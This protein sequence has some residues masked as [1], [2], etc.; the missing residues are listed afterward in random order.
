M[1]DL[2]DAL[3]HVDVL[4]ERLA[5]SLP[6]RRKP[7]MPETA[8]HVASGKVRE[9]YE[10]DDERLLLVASD[11]ISTFDVILGTEIP[12]KDGAHW[13]FRVLVRADE[14]HRPE[15]LPRPPARRA[16]DRGAAAEHAADRM[17]RARLPR[18]LGLK[19]YQATGATS[20]HSLPAGMSESDQLPQPIFTPATKAQTGH[21]E[22]ID[23]D[24]AAELVGADVLEQVEQ[25]AIALYD[26]AAANAAERGIIIADT[27]FELG[28]DEEG[29][30]VLGDE[31]F[32]PDSSRFW[33]AD[34]YRPGGAQRPSTSSSC[35]TTA[36]GSAGTRP[37]QALS[38]RGR[39]QRD[40][41]PLCRGVRTADGYR[42]RRLPRRS[43]GG[44]PV[45]ATVLVRPKEGILDPQGEAVE[46]LCAARLLGGRGA[47]RRVIDID[48]AAES[49]AAA[50]EEIERMRAPLDQPTHRE[51]RDRAGGGRGSNPAADRR[52]GLPR[53]GDDRDA[54]GPSA[55]SARSN[56]RLAW[57]GGAPALD[58]VVLPGG[59]SYGDYLRCGAIACFS[60]A[61]G[62]V[63]DHAAEGGLVLGICNGFQ[64]LCEAGLLR[65]FSGRTLL[66]FVCRDVGLIVERADSPF[67]TRCEAGQQL[68]IPVKLR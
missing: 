13:P 28:F 18:R 10:L 53:V 33:P 48:V 68:T 44:R 38:P 59:F 64:I 31:A 67:T 49:P 46:S 50:R 21:D 47:G 54:A 7:F 6:A 14:G 45:K 25:I 37:R 62:A 4:F 29:A 11:R 34:D 40:T 20:G 1:F 23:R 2:A 26:H 16:L 19:D 9:I 27:K 12:D 56:P 35:A 58:A 32:T 36:R 3:K 24:Q 60:P 61:M 15:P 65:G 63:A 52:P 41:R 39:R 66:Q 22:N 30:I 8:Q 43:R 5:T 17:R 42:V 55:L 51:L 57:R